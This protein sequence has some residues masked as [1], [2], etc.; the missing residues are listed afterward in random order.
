MHKDSVVEMSTHLFFILL[1]RW[2]IKNLEEYQVHVIYAFHQWHTMRDPFLFMFL[3]VRPLN[4]VFSDSIAWS[5]GLSWIGTRTSLIVHIDCDMMELIPA[6]FVVQ[7]F[8]YL[9]DVQFHD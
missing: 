5:L 6:S 9:L 2:R 8:D 3:I 7:T 1:C 4:W